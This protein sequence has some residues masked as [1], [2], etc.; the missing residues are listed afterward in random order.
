MKI[1]SVNVVA[2]GK[3]SNVNINFADGINLLQQSNGF[4]KSTLCAFVRAML[5]GLNYSYKTVEGVRANDVT[6]YMPWNST[7]KF[8]GSMQIYHEG[9]TYRIERFFG[10][11]ARAESLQ[12]VDLSTG[13]QLD[14]DSVGEYFLGLTVE[15]YDR[16]TYLP[17]EYVEIASNENFD[18]KLANL[19]QD[20]TQNYDDIQAKLRNYKKTFRY[21]RGNGGIIYTLENEVFSLQN[22]LRQAQN[23]AN[24]RVRMT[25]QLND[26]E[27]QLQSLQKEQTYLQTTVDQLQQQ[28]YQSKP[29]SADVELA[30]K[31]DDLDRK[32]SAVP[33][34]VENDYQNFNQQLAQKCLLEK[35]VKSFPSTK[36][37]F[38]VSSVIALLFAVI[39]AVLQNY[40]LA[41]VGVGVLVAIVVTAVC[42][43]K[44]N[45]KNVGAK[46]ED[47]N[48]KL[49][50]IVSKY[51]NPNGKTLPQLKDEFWKYLNDYQTN[52]NVRKALGNKPVINTNQSQIEAQLKQTKMQVQ[53]VALQ[54]QNLVKTQHQLTFTLAQPMASAV[55]IA[56]ELQA[57]QQ[58]LQQA[59]HKYDVADKTAEILAQAKESLSSAYLPE[60]CL[61]TEQLLNGITN[62][63]YK[64]VTDRTFAI[65]LQQNGQTK[66]LSAFSRGIREITLLCFRVALSQLLYGK[67]IP[68]LIVDDAF[69]NFDEQNF[70]RAT[71]LLKQLSQTTQIIYC[72]CHNR[73]GNL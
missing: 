12:V 7:Q 47:I 42:V 33:T 30:Q 63:N 62:G 44:I 2:F 11:T 27:L 34:T 1:V 45:A 70:A 6:K 16:S 13:K 24:E 14:I 5:Y 68:L 53:N 72:T 52:V 9:K 35:T 17:Q 21:E 50:T 73:T 43:S 46:I 36:K 23:D 22:A 57:K 66:P 28:L 20:S 64:V 3:L 48:N 51:I 38:A 67:D 71:E 25:K 49:T 15:S 37:I 61:R 58:L 32:I 18:A 60:L 55:E 59:K 54:Q 19:V 41:F 56:E 8:G 40:T 4:G 65:S 29:S 26:V 69:V 10:N 39:M 31:I